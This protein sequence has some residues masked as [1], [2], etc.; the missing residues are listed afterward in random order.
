MAARGQTAAMGATRRDVDYDLGYD[1]NGWDTKGFRRPEAGLP[2]Q[3]RAGH[4]AAPAGGAG[5]AAPARRSPGTRRRAPRRDGGGGHPAWPHRLA[6]RR[7]ASWAGTR[8]RPASGRPRRPG[9]GP[10]RAGAGGGPAGPGGPADQAARGGCGGPGRRGRWAGPGPRSRAA[11]GGTGRC[12][13]PLGVLLGVHR[14]R[15][16]ARRHRDG[17]G[18]RADARPH[19]RRWRRPASRS[20]WSTRATAPSSAGS[21]PPT[22]SC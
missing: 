19:R 7:P 2:R 18:L 6:P 10:P 12:A 15:R 13:R 14:R 11:G 1:A 5:T 9:P 20:P 17:R 4:A 8:A 3:P 22:G 16:R 21:A